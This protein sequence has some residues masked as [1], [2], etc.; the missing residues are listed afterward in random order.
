MD[1]YLCRAGK[2]GAWAKRA[3]ASC[4][5]RMAVKDYRQLTK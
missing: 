2:L 4:L 3:L 1:A 5:S